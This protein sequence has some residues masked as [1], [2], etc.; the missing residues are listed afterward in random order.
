[1]YANSIKIDYYCLENDLVQ[2]HPKRKS[3]HLLSF[4]WESKTTTNSGSLERSRLKKKMMSFSIISLFIMIF[5]SWDFYS[6]SSEKCAFQ[7]HNIE[8]N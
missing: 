1:M 3:K 4:L 8:T 6:N 2:L 5:F 7:S